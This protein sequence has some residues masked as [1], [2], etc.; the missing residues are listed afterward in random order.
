MACVG[1]NPPPN[2]HG[3][4]VGLGMKSSLYGRDW[5]LL[6]GRRLGKLN[7]H[8]IVEGPDLRMSCSLIL[9][10]A[11]T[12]SLSHRYGSFGGKSQWMVSW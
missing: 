3:F 9:Y 4:Q 2:T 1:V 5:H 11:F 7:A 10:G 8:L 12:K 6:V